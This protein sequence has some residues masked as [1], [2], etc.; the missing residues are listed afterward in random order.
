MEEVQEVGGVRTL[1]V[2]PTSHTQV[3]EPHF[4]EALV[5][6]LFTLWYDQV[7]PLTHTHTHTHT[8]TPFETYKAIRQQE[9]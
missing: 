5:G 6:V 3:A 2:P 1:R 9:E 8:H 7:A 4:N